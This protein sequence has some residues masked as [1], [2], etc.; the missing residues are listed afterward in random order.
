MN[1]ASLPNSVRPPAQINNLYR[2]SSRDAE[3]DTANVVD[4]NENPAS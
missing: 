3:V 2:N 4:N 1:I